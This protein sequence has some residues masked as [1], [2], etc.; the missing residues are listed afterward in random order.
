MRDT[1]Q[2]YIVETKFK[3]ASVES[4]RAGG[5]EVDIL[6]ANGLA[7]RTV[8]RIVEARTRRLPILDQKRVE[9]VEG[10]TTMARWLSTA[11]CSCSIGGKQT[12]FHLIF[13]C[14]LARCVKARKQAVEKMAERGVEHDQWIATWKALERGCEIGGGGLDEKSAAGRS[15]LRCA[16]AIIRPDDAQSTLTLLKGKE[17]ARSTGV[18]LL[19]IA[20][21][22]S[23]GV[24]DAVRIRKGLWERMETREKLASAFGVLRA[25]V[26]SVGLPR[27]I[28]SNETDE[29]GG[30][31]VG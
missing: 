6:Y 8:D 25:C 29:E 9:S 3:P 24:D 14:T 5:M 30:R 12:A 19:F 21:C 28:G 18:H 11:T 7:P 26:L 2:A 15:A 31:Q 10:D 27:G 17:K 23:A 1:Y 13:R 20:E 4:L 22:L 16:L